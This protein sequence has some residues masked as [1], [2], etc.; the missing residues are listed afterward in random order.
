MTKQPVDVTLASSDGIETHGKG[1]LCL[2][3]PGDRLK[4]ALAVLGITV[5]VAGLLIPIPIVH[6]LG[7]PL[8]LVLGL[9]I[10]ARQMSRTQRL[11]P[12]RLPCPKC[13]A[14]NRV[15]GGLG[16]RSIEHPI[17]R[18]CDSCRRTLQLR[19]MSK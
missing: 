2:F 7:I 4:R 11:L 8:T 15:G 16:L 19:I 1:T 9:G 6:L 14:P 5:L 12:M 13:A 17:E 3:S 10:A 18:M